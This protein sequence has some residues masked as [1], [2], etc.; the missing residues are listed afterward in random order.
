MRLLSTAA[1]IAL[2]AVPALAGAATYDIDSAHSVASFTVRHLMV[3]NVRGE[4][5]KTTG[6]VVYDEKD[7]TKSTVEA[8]IDVSTLSTRDP[9]RDGHLKSPDFFDAEKFPTITFKST[10]VEKAGQ[11]KLK[12]L[13]NL[14]MHGVTKPVT[15][16]VEGPSGEVKDPWGNTKVGA[17]ATTKINR[18]DFGVKWNAPVPTGGVVVGEEVIVNLEVELLKKAATVAGQ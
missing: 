18:N 17:S 7:P 8:T 9:K 6:T 15:L 16:E 13:G 2:A 1:F 14:T 11:G 3:S 12:V 10:K 5:G 4:F